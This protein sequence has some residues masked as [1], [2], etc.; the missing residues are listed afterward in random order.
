MAGRNCLSSS[1]LPA[2]TG[3]AQTDLSRL[4]QFIGEMA[5]QI[6]YSMQDY[7]S[8]ITELEQ[9]GSAAETEGV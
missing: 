3:Q 5:D 4:R 8:R 2:L 9:S 7:D 1:E 6:R